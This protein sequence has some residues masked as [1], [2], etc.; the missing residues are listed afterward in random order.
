MSTPAGALVSREA[1]SWAVRGYATAVTALRDPHLVVARPGQSE[2]DGRHGDQPPTARSGPST[3][4]GAPS[5]PEF[6]QSWFTVGS[7]HGAVKG[8]LARPFAARQIERFATVVAELARLRVDRLPDD[9]DLVGDC[10]VPFS[11]DCAAALTGIPAGEANRL[12]A[13]TRLMTAAFHGVARGADEPLRQCVRY[14]RAVTGHLLTADEGTP[15]AGALREVAA[16]LGEWTATAVLAQL[17][18]AGVEPTVT[19]AALTCRELARDPGLPE[20]APLERIADEALRRTPPFPRVHRTTAARCGCLG[21]RIE[22]GERVVVDIEAANHDP[23]VFGDGRFDPSRTAQPLTFGLGA[24]HCLGAAFARMQIS[25]VVAALARPEARV[26]PAD[27]ILR[28]TAH[29]VVATAMP[30][31][32]TAGAA[33]G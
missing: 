19:G 30:F 1:Q 6:F 24:Y 2:Q 23:A 10:L 25:A 13:V 4:D 29:T 32:R 20:R 16:E 27:L 15:L 18:T 5:V 11:V 31:R 26:A 33:R 14:L 21:V 17:L 12:M 22:A 8:V 7:A 9:G 28:R 3:N